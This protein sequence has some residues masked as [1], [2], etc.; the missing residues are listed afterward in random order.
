MTSCVFAK[1]IQ[2]KALAGTEF[3]GRELLKHVPFH[4][5]ELKNNRDIKLVSHA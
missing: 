4:C 5:I 3:A 1:G 2:R